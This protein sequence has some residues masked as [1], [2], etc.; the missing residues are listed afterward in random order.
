MAESK[1]NTTGD[2]IEYNRSEK[3]L[4]EGCGMRRRGLRR[5]KKGKEGTTEWAVGREEQREQKLKD[6]NRGSKN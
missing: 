5:N 4:I 1:Q 6:R 3:K 2:T